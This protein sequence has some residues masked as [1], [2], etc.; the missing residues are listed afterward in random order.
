M[1]FDL[2]L[3]PRGRSGLSDGPLGQFVV[4]GAVTWRRWSQSFQQRLQRASC[5][6]SH[7]YTRARTQA[8]A[9]LICGQTHLNT[10]YHWV[11][12]LLR[13]SSLHLLLFFLSLSLILYFNEQ[14]SGRKG[15]K[16]SKTSD[17][18]FCVITLLWGV[19]C[20]YSITIWIVR[21][22]ISSTSLKK[23]QIH[24]PRGDSFGSNP[25]RFS[26]RTYGRLHVWISPQTWVI[27]CVLL[28]LNPVPKCVSTCDICMSIFLHTR[29]RKR[30]LFMC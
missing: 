5:A 7:T 15:K 8:H 11:R 23:G 21:N 27:A 2:Y 18:C 28:G 14:P 25:A 22:P 13:F 10:W 17:S 16:H 12:A 26:L 19:K 29:W 4:K 20:I 1:I 30:A 9:P 6:P 24:H 3:S